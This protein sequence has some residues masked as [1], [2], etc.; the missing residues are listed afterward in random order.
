MTVVST[1]LSKLFGSFCELSRLLYE[2]RI[3]RAEAFM[4][5]E[6]EKIMEYPSIS[7]SW[8]LFRIK[9]ETKEPEREENAKAE[10]K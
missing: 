8:A 9:V 1:I 6:S 10:I 4:T 5:E 2:K 3:I 7:Y